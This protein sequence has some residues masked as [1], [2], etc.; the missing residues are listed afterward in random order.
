[1]DS[2]H[3]RLMMAVQPLCRGKTRV[4]NP[5][6]LFL[7]SPFEEGTEPVYASRSATKMY[8][9]AARPLAGSAVL[10]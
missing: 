8:A 9:A 1:V 6:V 4:P 2:P 7:H 5:S 3:H 10:P